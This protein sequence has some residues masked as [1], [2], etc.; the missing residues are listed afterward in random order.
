MKRKTV[1][2][3]DSAEKFSV[4]PQPARGVAAVGRVMGPVDQAAFRVPFILPGK[5]DRVAGLQIVEAR[6]L[7]NV[8]NDQ[9]GPAGVEPKDEF[10][11]AEAPGVIFEDFDHQS[12]AM[13]LDIAEVLSE[14]PVNTAVMILLGLGR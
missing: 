10:L 5:L 9:Q 11:V 2:R 4:V 1:S 14:S 7:T 3:E 6:G 8:V 13:N 12:L